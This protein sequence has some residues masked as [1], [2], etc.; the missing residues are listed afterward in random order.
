[1]VIPNQI[2]RNES[3]S[4]QDRKSIHTKTVEIQDK[5]KN[6]KEKLVLLT[7]L[8]KSNPETEKE[9]ETNPNTKNYVRRYKVSFKG[10]ESYREEEII[11]QATKTPGINDQATSFDNCIEELFVTNAMQTIKTYEKQDQIGSRF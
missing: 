2:K 5:N 11:I 8:K 6:E 9:I 4:K 1:M 10:T 7:T 3:A